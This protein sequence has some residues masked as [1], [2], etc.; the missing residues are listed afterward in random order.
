MLFLFTLMVSN[1]VLADRFL[2]QNNRGQQRYKNS[3][4]YNAGQAARQRCTERDGRVITTISDIY[5]SRV[6]NDLTVNNGENV[7]I[8]GIQTQFRNLT[9]SVGGVLTVPSGTII[10]CLGTATINGTIIVSPITQGAK[11][12][13]SELTSSAEV[14]GSPAHPGISH[15]IAGNGAVGAGADIIGGQSGSDEAPGG[16]ASY[17]I[18]RLAGGGGGVG[19]GIGGLGGG[20]LMIVSFQ[21]LAVGAQA[22][23]SAKGGDA[24]SVSGG[25]GAGGVVILASE[26]AVSVTG[27]GVIDV[28]G[29]DGGNSSV[30]TVLAM[31]PGGG[32]AGGLVHIITPSYNAN[33]NAANVAGGTAGTITSGT[34]GFASKW[35]GGGAGGALFASGGSGGTIDSDNS[36]TFLPAQNGSDGDFVVTDESPEGYRF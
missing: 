36:G 22:N 8:S 32:G 12:T 35:I 10:R 9:V 4:T 30:G 25:G 1:D 28:S 14:Q 31:G 19:S 34:L 26:E 6:N 11:R 15:A 18:S 24:Q 17:R 13:I 5:G 29:G 33:L 20:S 27:T 16:V 2:C 23:I 21:T 7:V 3:I